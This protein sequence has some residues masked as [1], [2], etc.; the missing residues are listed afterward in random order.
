VALREGRDCEFF[1]ED[2]LFGVESWSFTRVG[3]GYELDRNATMSQ[4]SKP[5]SSDWLPAEHGLLQIHTMPE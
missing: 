1:L 2:L 3:F 4:R 5:D